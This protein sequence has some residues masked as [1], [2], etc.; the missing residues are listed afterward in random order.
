[1]MQLE[2][3][4]RRGGLRGELALAIPPTLVVIAAIFL[5]EGITRQKL[6][7]ASL[8]ASA[9]LIY[10]DPMHRMNTIR[11]M[12]TAQIIGFVVGIGASMLLGSGYVAGAV[13]MAITIFLLI[14][15]DIVHPPAISTALAFAFVATKDKVLLLFLVAIVMISILAIL[16]RTALFT[17]RRIE[18]YAVRLEH[19][20][21][22]KVEH[23]YA[24]TVHHHGG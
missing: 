24:E 21:V 14:V 17:L 9:F 10:Y 1:M 5:I 8:A 23:A 15:L 13:A 7:F 2:S 19:E 18:R 4:M 3:A 11:V 22:Q 20:A 6:L 12:I 16:Q